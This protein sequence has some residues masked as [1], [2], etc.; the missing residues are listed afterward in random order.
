MGQDTGNV[1]VMDLGKFKT[2]ETVLTCWHKSMGHKVKILSILSAMSLFPLSLSMMPKGTCITYPLQA[3]L[4]VW[5]I[6]WFT[7]CWRVSSLTH[8]VEPGLSHI[9][10]QRMGIEHFL[11]GQ[12]IT[13]AKV[14]YQS[15]RQWQRLG[16]K[17][18]S[19]RISNVCHLRRWWRFCQSHFLLL[20][21]TQMRGTQNARRC[22]SCFSV[23]RC[24]T[25]KWWHRSW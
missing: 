9:R 11:H 4:T 18:F 22:K 5:T 6:S 16:L 14:S 13:M 8:L 15:V 7:I 10:W 12:I 21:R 19:T 3:R 25:W 20:I 1:S 2:H 24:W 23:F 17:I